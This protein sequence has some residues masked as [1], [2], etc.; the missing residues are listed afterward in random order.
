[1]PALERNLIAKYGEGFDPVLPGVGMMYALAESKESFLSAFK[2]KAKNAG[3]DENGL[4]FMDNGDVSF[5]LF[6]A[7]VLHSLFT[8]KKIER[9]DSHD[10]F[11]YVLVDAR[12]ESSSSKNGRFP[13]AIAIKPE[14]LIDPDSLNEIIEMFENIRGSVHICVMVSC[15]MSVRFRIKC[16]KFLFMIIGKRVWIA[17]RSL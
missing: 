11:K 2:V 3:L 9:S 6:P 4:T 14:Q 12:N 8:K 10:D 5:R 17:S 7:D 13:T 1:M 16:F 15:I